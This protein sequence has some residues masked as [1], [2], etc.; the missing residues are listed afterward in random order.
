MMAVLAIILVLAM[1]FSVAAPLIYSIQASAM[2]TN[3]KLDSKVVVGLENLKGAKE[4]IGMDK[5]SLDMSIGYDQQYIVG[6]ETPFRGVLTNKGQGFRGELQVKVYSYLNTVSNDA[7]SDGG[8]YNIYY[9]KVELAKGAA[10]QMNLDINIGVICDFFEVTLVDEKNKT[11]FRKNISAKALDPATVMVGVLTES[12]ADVAYLS[13]LNMTE[14]KE[15]YK[16]EYSKTVFLNG[17]SFPENETILKNFKAIIIDDFDTKTLSKEQLKSLQDWIKGGGMLILSTGPKAE[18]VLGGLGGLVEFQLGERQ[19]ITSFPTI[20]NALKIQ[21]EKYGAMDITPI[22]APGLKD[23]FMENGSSIT[24]SMEFGMG[25]IIVHNFSLSLAPIAEFP[26]LVSL[27]RGMYSKEAPTLFIPEMGG[28][29]EQDR[30]S[31]MAERFPVLKTG[32]IYWILGCVLVYILLIGPI[33]Y[34]VLKKKDKREWGWVIIPTLSILFMVVVFVM[35]QNTYY[36]NGIIN[37][38]SV[39]KMTSDSSVVKTDI[40]MAIKSANKGT[41]VFSMDDKV[42]IKVPSGEPIYYRSNSQKERYVQKIL[43]G[44]NSTEITYFDNK[45]W[46][47]NRFSTE[48][49][50]DL[51]GTLESTIMISNNRY[52]GKII[53]HT[54]LDFS[55]I[56]IGLGGTYKI[57]DTLKAGESLNVDY[58]MEDL[59]GTENGIYAALDSA[60]GDLDSGNSRTKLAKEKKLTQE[61]IYSLTQQRDLIQICEDELDEGTAMGSISTSGFMPIVFYGF[62]KEPVISADKYVNG[63]KAVERNIG[64]YQMRFELNLESMKRFDIPFGSIV[65]ASVKSEQ[66]INQYSN[67]RMQSKTIYAEEQAEVE[68][69]FQLPKDVDLE[70]FQVRNQ[71]DSA[72]FYE[73][74]EIYNIKTETWEKIEESAYK[75]PMDYIT[76]QGNLRIKLFMKESGEAF[77]PDLRIKGGGNYAGN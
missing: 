74:P 18:K 21:G 19:T 41:V 66:H 75:N 72:I 16:A 24:S 48:I 42:D 5:F 70:L 6:K 3:V 71:T 58:T 30:I 55:G 34:V 2:T 12:P 38:V 31:R 14:G 40:N 43:S 69:M 73:K 77:M 39:A 57:F 35:S 54:N 7:E 10:K 26:N 44:G 56:I 36:K 1:V 49:E 9:Q 62:N 46:G 17:I 13:G 52:V 32:G 27:L 11:V 29:N 23:I 47:T 4:E 68:C 37:V 15:D 61:E 22:T 53:N 25:E 63:K 50:K 51:G 64:L 65:P 60:F 59:K 45:S 33:L 20:N 67:N 8:E 28:N 76:E